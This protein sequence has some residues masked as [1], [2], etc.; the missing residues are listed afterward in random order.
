[1]AILSTSFDLSIIFT[2]FVISSDTSFTFLIFLEAFVIS[3]VLSITSVVPLDEIISCALFAVF[4]VS[5]TFNTTLL[6][7]ASTVSTFLAGFKNFIALL[8]VLKMPLAIGIAP[9]I[10]VAKSSFSPV[11]ISYPTIPSVTP[12]ITP[13]GEKSKPILKIVLRKF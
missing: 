2:S 12:F 10:L 4:I 7:S 5:S 3:V 6:P 11:T 13:K 1:M 9:I 8:P